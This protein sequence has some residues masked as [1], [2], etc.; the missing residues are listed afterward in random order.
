MGINF[1]RV[2]EI[3]KFNGLRLDVFIFL[4][5]VLYKVF[6]LLGYMKIC[7]FCRN[8]ELC[9]LDVKMKWFFRMVLVF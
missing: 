7:V 1:L 5:N 6:V 9:R 8:M 2:G 3:M 4:V